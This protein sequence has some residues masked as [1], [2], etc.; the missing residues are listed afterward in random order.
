[1]VLTY[2]YSDL[3]NIKEKIKKDS[4]K[5]Q[6]KYFFIKSYQ[7][8]LNYIYKQNLAKNKTKE[9]LENNLQD[10]IESLLDG[11]LQQYKEL[12]KKYKSKYATTK[13]YLIS[14]D[15]IGLHFDNI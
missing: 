7:E 15:D 10:L 14:P 1:M 4:L 2:N 8:T 5:E 12:E 3:Q 11:K 13:D 9:D 6:D